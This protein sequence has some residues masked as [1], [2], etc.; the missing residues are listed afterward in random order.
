MRESLDTRMPAAVRKRALT[1]IIRLFR[2]NGSE[3]KQGG[4]PASRAYRFTGY[5]SR[6]NSDKFLEVLRLLLY[7]H[8]LFGPGGSCLIHGP[9][10]PGLLFLR[11]CFPVSPGLSG[12]GYEPHRGNPFLVE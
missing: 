12:H 3:K 11:I 1:G 10:A 7:M 5:V 8:N 9:Q 2:L 6:R 4:I